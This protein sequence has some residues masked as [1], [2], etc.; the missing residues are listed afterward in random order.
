[1]DWGVKECY[2]FLLRSSMLPSTA[3][4]KC[5]QALLLFVC[6]IF[7][8]AQV[9]S[10]ESELTQLVISPSRASREISKV[11]SSVTVITAKEL[12]QKKQRTVIEALSAVPGVQV[13]QSGGFGGNVSIFLRGANA[14]HT[15]VIVDGIEVN[16]PVSTARLPSIAN[17]TLDNV[18]RIE[19]LR[20]PQSVLYGSDALGGVISITTK[21]GAGAANGA[22]SAEG[23]SYQTF[24]EKASLNGEE[25]NLHYS[26]AGSRID[27]GSISQAD[28]SLGN[29]E[30]DSY[31]N[32]SFSGRV[33][34]LLNEDSELSAFFRS[35]LSKTDLDNFGGAGGDDP[36]RFFD[37]KQFFTRIQGSTK[38]FGM[39]QTLGLSYS[40]QRFSDSNS[41]DDI[42]ILD[43]AEGR[44]SSDMLKVDFLNRIALDDA[45]IAFGLESE[46]ERADSTYVSQSLFGE[47]RDDLPSQSNRT[48][49]AFLQADLDWLD[50]FSTTAGIRVDDAEFLD[51]QVTWR[52]GQN[53]HIPESGTTLRASVGSGFKVPSLFQRF[54]QYGRED[55]LAEKSLG[56]DAGIEQSLLSGDLVLGATYFWNNFKNLITFDS[57]TFL[58][59]NVADAKTQGIEFS[60]KVK[61]PF[62][63][64]LI[65]SYT[66]MKP[67]DETTG[68]DLLRR[69]RHKVGFDL[70]NKITEELTASLSG[71]YLGERLDN[72]FST[73]PASTRNLGGYTIFNLALNYQATRDI[74]FYT[75]VENLSDREYESVIG[76][77]APGAAGYAGVVYKY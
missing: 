67:Q 61:L 39:Y 6:P 3:R 21:K 62:R 57:S 33:D 7:M 32:S 64:E 9:F 65:S 10:Q 28:A 58:Y 27:S 35:H 74:E 25:G 41:P 23:G 15:L 52:T 26:L 4:H 30:D 46:N 17:M 20:G 14:E 12:E 18:E 47:F 71:Y 24:T 19:I 48:N 44:F 1:V 8:Q 49:A 13:V 50:R 29:T 45:S 55:L 73:F 69:A 5:F 63:T 53:V 59:Q 43:S 66:Y 36:N 37:Q 54:S 22:L 2:L 72:D 34:Y 51:P 31:G 40:D 11:A 75:K 38:S 76:F 68:E 70:R 42:N 16:D 60:A 77:G 56:V